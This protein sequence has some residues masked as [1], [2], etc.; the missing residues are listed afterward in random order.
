MSEDT[1]VRVR[2]SETGEL[3]GSG[4]SGELE[5]RA[6]SRFLGYFHNPDAT[7]E[8]TTADGFFRTGDIGRLREDG[9]FIYETRGGAMP[10]GSAASWSRPARSRTN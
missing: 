5:I 2:D 10:C 1:V 9:S 4:V 6:R 3:A 7:R 8:A